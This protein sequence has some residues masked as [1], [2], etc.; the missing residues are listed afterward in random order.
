M[1]ARASTTIAYPA[2]FTLVG[3]MNPC[4]CGHAGDP[5]TACLCTPADVGRYRSKL[6]GP[7]VDRMDMHVTVGAVPVRDLGQSARGDSS[8]S[9]RQRV[10]RAHAAQRRRYAKIFGD[11][12]NAHVPGRWLSANTRISAEARGMLEAASEKMSLSARGY[13]RVIKVA[14]TIADLDGDTGIELQHVAEAV[15]YRVPASPM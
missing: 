6:S 12:A 7:L 5:V 11:R 9:M 10:A 13:H 2:R 8:A 4:P 15:Q 3:A 1:I 14:R